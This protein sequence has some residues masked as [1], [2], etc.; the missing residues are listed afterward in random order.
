MDG[1][2]ISANAGEKMVP[3]LDLCQKVYE[4]E[5]IIGAGDNAEA[6]DLQSNILKIIVDDSMTNYYS[7]LCE[8]FKWNVDD[9]ILS[10][11]R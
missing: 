8:K 4:Y 7:H 11:M 2:L 10:E 3:N 9:I 5:T 6:F 1:L